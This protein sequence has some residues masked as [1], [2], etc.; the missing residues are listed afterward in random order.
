MQSAS[1]ALL[2]SP[3][4]LDQRACEEK[5]LSI[6]LTE[7]VIE[8]NIPNMLGYE[9][10]AM[11]SAASFAKIIGFA[12]ERIEDLKTAVSEACLNAIKH[13]NKG[14]WEARVIVTMS[15]KKNSLNIC[16]KDEGS[17]ITE[18]PQE[19]NIERNI[20]NVESRKGIGI[21]LI[22]QLVDQVEFNELTKKGHVVKMTMKL[23]Q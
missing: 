18:L 19:P 22:K 1:E 3:E 23:T 5:P 9:Q 15:F 14:R 2:C 13:G 4:I 16:V 10:I 17:G 21:Y 6:I 8:V 12:Q 7:H 11:E 20:E